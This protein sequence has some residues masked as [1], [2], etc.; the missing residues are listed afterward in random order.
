VLIIKEST[1]RHIFFNEVNEPKLVPN[2]RGKIRKP[3]TKSLAGILKCRDQNFVDFVCKCLEWDPNIRM[4]PRE[5]LMHDWILEG[6]PPRV[7]QHHRKIHGE[8]SIGELK[9]ERKLSTS[10]TH[11]SEA[12]SNKSSKNSLVLNEKDTQVIDPIS[13]IVT[14]RSQ[15]GDHAKNIQNIAVKLTNLD[16]SSIKLSMNKTMSTKLTFFPP[17]GSELQQ[18]IAQ[19]SNN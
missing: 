5:A 2:S 12:K 10:S 4:N 19:K 17:I 14:P 9:F 16:A 13:K 18:H 1:R 6:L 3:S 8:P 15:R 7:L 11:R